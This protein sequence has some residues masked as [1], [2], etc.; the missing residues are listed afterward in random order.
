MSSSPKLAPVEAFE[1]RE[2]GGVEAAAKRRAAENRVAPQNGSAGR[3]TSE[4]LELKLAAARAEG[5][6]EGLQ[7][8]QDSRSKSN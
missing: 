6:R 2:P 1:Y 3:E 8:A 5:I 7:Q 4:Q